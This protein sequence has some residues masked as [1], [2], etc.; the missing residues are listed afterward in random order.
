MTD[1]GTTGSAAAPRRSGGRA[2]VLAAVGVIAAV[3]LLGAAAGNGTR[4]AGAAAPVA[5]RQ[6]TSTT[7]PGETSTSGEE[8]ATTAPGAGGQPG[9]GIEVEARVVDLVFRTGRISGGKDSATVSESPGTTE[10]D[11][12][13]DVL[14]A[15]NSD[16]LSPAAQAEL[17]ETAKLIRE[18]AKGPVRV[19]GH[20]DSIGS[21]GYNL[22][23]SQRRAE[24]VRAA[25]E[26]L[27]AGRPTQ[28]SVQGFGASKP[29][30]PNRNPDGSDNPK[31][32][33]R[34]RRV[35]VAINT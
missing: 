7:V 23:L 1:Q 18:R 31:G 25:L 13:A 11:L 24:A 21:Q 5:F 4:P 26:R 9:V 35:T 16:R 15:F 33:Q 32:R 20:T 22:G 14:F 27:L 12:A 17:Q 30:A 19:E 6:E 3:V 8:S 28:F 29:I 2:A 10:V 34:N